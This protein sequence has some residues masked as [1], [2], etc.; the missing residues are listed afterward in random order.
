VTSSADVSDP[1]L[2]KS[3]ENGREY[4]MKTGDVRTYFYEEAKDVEAQKCKAK[5]DPEMRAVLGRK[6]KLLKETNECIEAENKM[7]DKGYPLMLASL[8]YMR[9][10]YFAAAAILLNLPRKNF[11]GGIVGAVLLLIQLGSQLVGWAVTLRRTEVK[12]YVRLLSEFRATT[13]HP[14]HSANRA[15]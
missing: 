2:I 9:V 12:A 7:K 13:T 4:D 14:Q 3:E 15:S 8:L 5:T 10:L 1:T 11:V 6:E